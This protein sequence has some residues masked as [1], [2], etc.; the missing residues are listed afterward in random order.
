M[1]S[2]TNIEKCMENCSELR[3]DGTCKRKD[4]VNLQHCTTNP[5]KCCI[6]CS[7]ETEPCDAKNGICTILY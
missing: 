3:T 5:K 1:E 4:D 7:G 6:M 2:K